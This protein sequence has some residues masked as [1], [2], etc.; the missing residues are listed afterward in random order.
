MHDGPATPSYDVAVAIPARSES[1]RIVECLTALSR[2]P[3]AGLRVGVFVLCNNCEDDTARRI[4]AF[5]HAGVDIRVREVAFSQNE[6]HAGMA[7]RT[8][9]QWART[10][11]DPS[12]AQILCSTDADSRVAAD[13]L[14]SLMAAFGR[15]V[16]AVAGAVLFDPV[17]LADLRVPPLRQLEDRYAVLQAQVEHR[18]DP[19]DHDHWPNHIWAWGANLS[20]RS[21][22][23]DRAGGI[24]MAPLAEDRAFM[25]QLHRVDAKVRH[26]PE[27]QVL[28]SARVRGRAPGGLADLVAAHTRGEDLPCDAALEPIGDA[29]RRARLR[30]QVRFAY[31]QGSLG[32]AL[33]GRLRLERSA[34]EQ[35]LD[36]PFAGEA[37]SL[38]E[39]AS[40][41]L[42]R[43][44]LP[45]SRLPREIVQAERL[46]AKSSAG[47]D[48][49]DSARASGSGLWSAG[50][51][52][53]G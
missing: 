2:Q 9:M 49:D 6:A 10:M 33:A 38:I 15:G 39:A 1:Q 37:W 11:L 52:A 27:V 17:E 30:R 18:A 29:S 13:W 12:G 41:T 47:A 42:Q 24:P 46:L 31:Q 19:R 25:A 53:P 35:A 26:A 4:G 28:T 40:P 36:A 14:P 16:D 22:A 23:F 5:V 44:R 50:P 21:A 51:P 32:R 7:R 43:R 45:L 48:R 34:V 8:A 20:V 3:R